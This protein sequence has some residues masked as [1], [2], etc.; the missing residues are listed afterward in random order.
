MEKIDRL[1][2]KTEEWWPRLQLFFAAGRDFRAVGKN[3]DGSKEI[4]YVEGRFP[5]LLAI[6][7]LFL[8]G[9]WIL[10]GLV[11]K[12]VVCI[13]PLDQSQLRRSLRILLYSNEI[14]SAAYDC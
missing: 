13:R 10:N 7:R 8:G 4:G 3:N 1:S 6:R 12:R 2:F 9:H 5:E 14:Y 11:T